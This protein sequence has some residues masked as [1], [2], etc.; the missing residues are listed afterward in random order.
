MQ[1]LV[2]AFLSLYQST[3]AWIVAWI[4]SVLISTAVFSICFWGW[5]NHGEAGSTTIRNIGL[6]VAAIIGLPLAIWRSKVAERQ[7]ATAQRQRKMSTSLR[8]RRER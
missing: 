7:A 5:L 6:V 2:N 4:M 1:R 8:V 3:T